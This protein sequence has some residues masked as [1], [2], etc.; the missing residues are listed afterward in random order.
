M[1]ALPLEG[2]RI[3][4]ITVVWSGP[5]A[6]RFMAALGAEVIRVES[7]RYYPNMNRGQTPYPTKESLAGLSGMSAAYPDKDPGPDPYNRFGPFLLVS[8]GKR[9]V[10][11]ELDTAE[12]REAFHKLVAA[13]DVV[14]ENNSRALSSS[15]GIEWPQLSAVN[16]NLI[17]VKMTPLG[18]DG[19]YANAIGFGAHFE[20]LTGLAALRGHP[21]APP[22]DA[23]STYH[24]DDVAPHGVVFGVLA[25]LLHRERTGHGQLIEFP[26][27][28]YL[29]QGLGDAFMA[30]AEDNRQFR[31]DGNRHLTMV[32]GAYPCAGEDQWIAISLRDDADWAALVGALG[33]PGWAQD[34]RFATAVERRANQDAIDAL[35]AAKTAG[36]D[37]HELFASLQAAGIPAAPIY[38]EADAY[39]DPHFAER[40]V[41][42]A[43]TH[44]SA[45]T[46]DYP[47]FGARWSGM[48]LAWGRPAP[49]VGQDN[50]YV[51]K[52]LLGYSDDEYQAF[53]DKGLA[54]TVY[55]RPA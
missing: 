51:Y 28:E 15:L 8:Q 29:M 38:D 40:G 4:D 33:D 42:R 55:P 6:T 18:L 5:S 35:I 20:G 19:P 26:Q 11:M 34:A 46:Y 21:E 9:S 37:K 45:G 3:L 10:T 16:P 7:I 27:A 1:G 31:P 14:V 12:G 13:S 43:I 50:E 22:D 41:F 2:I 49:L 36:H 39:G 32:Q 25:A 48:D 44:P 53:L 24:M 30:A 52:E 47:S 54:G 23:G 17:L